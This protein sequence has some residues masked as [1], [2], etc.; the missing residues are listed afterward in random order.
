M[1]IN[2]R[3]TVRDLRC[4]PEFWFEGDAMIV[5]STIQL[6]GSATPGEVDRA[7]Q[8]CADVDLI[9]TGITRLAVATA[10]TLA[11]VGATETT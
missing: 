3:F 11:L 7:L 2:L 4:V 1:K 10:P 9:G 8:S 5:D 6:D